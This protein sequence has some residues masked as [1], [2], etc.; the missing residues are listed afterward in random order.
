MARQ[1]LVVDR[2]AAKNRAKNLTLSILKRHNSAQ[3]RQ[4]ERQITA[5]EAEIMALV[6]AEP[7][8]ARRFDILASIPGISTV[9]AFALVIDMP[10]LGTLGNGQAASLAGLAPIARSPGTG[11]A[12]PSSVEAGQCSAMRSTCQPSSPCASFP[13]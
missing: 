5:T 6:R 13:I 11:Q 3:L 8:L 2:T 12:T 4:I 10:E 9:T 7:D 1:A